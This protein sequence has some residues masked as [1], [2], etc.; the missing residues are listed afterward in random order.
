MAGLPARGCRGERARRHAL[1]GR[2]LQPVS[3]GRSPDRADAW[4]ETSESK[5]SRPRS[6]C[7]TRHEAG[8]YLQVKRL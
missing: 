4:H 5:R 2:A 7:E 3:R 6:V 1:E 8:H